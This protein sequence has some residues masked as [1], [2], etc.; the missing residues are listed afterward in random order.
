MRVYSKVW[1]KGALL[2]AVACVPGAGAP[3]AAAQ[4]G[5]AR[6]PVVLELFTSEGCSSCPPAD[7]W[8][9][10]LDAAQ[11]LPGAELIVLSEHVDYWDH[12]GWKDPYSSAALT[13]R[14]ENYVSV[15][16][17]SGVYTPQLILDGQVEVRFG[18]AHQVSE[19]FHKAAAEARIPVE[20]E[21]VRVADGAVTGHVV[22]AAEG[23]K[24]GD[25]LV[26]VA[27]DRTQTDVL[28]GEND[29][30]KLTNAGVVRALVKIGKT[31]KGRAFDRAFRVPVSAKDVGN[32]RVVA[33][34]QEGGWGPIV[35]AGMV[36]VGAEVATGR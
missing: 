18:D 21:D 35:G 4:A 25:V 20:I 28:G 5:A 33:L 1:R 36:K 8:V 30:K 29:G 2:V 9:E 34:V 22:V 23:S 15:M 26:A 16:S 7:Q 32:L 12:E 24:H 27:L 10:R 13:Q 17:L 11:P 31:E 14:Q 19:V 3:I 6:N